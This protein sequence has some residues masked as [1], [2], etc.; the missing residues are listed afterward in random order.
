MRLVNE[1]PDNVQAP[2]ATSARRAIPS[3]FTGEEA[4]ARRVA[5]RPPRRGRS[6]ATVSPRRAR[7]ALKA[8]QEP[9]YPPRCKRAPNTEA[10]PGARL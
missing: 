1:Y 5:S 4:E 9:P 3:A 8:P 6:P 2:G 7:G 10:L